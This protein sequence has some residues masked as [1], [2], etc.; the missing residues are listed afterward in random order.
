[1]SHAKVIICRKIVFMK[2]MNP[3][4]KVGIRAFSWLFAAS[5][6]FKIISN[7]TSFSLQVVCEIEFALSRDKLWDEF[8]LFRQKHSQQNVYM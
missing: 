3:H 1:M 6:E 5:Y 2:V 4:D 8:L 7:K